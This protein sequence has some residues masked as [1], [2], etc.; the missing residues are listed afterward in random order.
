VARVAC[1]DHVL[2][3]GPHL[4][5]PAIPPMQ[6]DSD[7]GACP[8]AHMLLCDLLRLLPPWWECAESCGRG[9]HARL[10]RAAHAASSR[11]SAMTRTGGVCTAPENQ[12]E[13]PMKKARREPDGGTV[14][15]GGGAARLQTRG[16][17]ALAQPLQGAL[18]ISQRAA[19]TLLCM[20]F[21]TGVFR[22]V[23]R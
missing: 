8:R 1:V 10:S 2:K 5:Q 16:A 9:G 4:Q 19:F 21:D 11:R 23:M 22:A 17:G 6:Q 14:V 18:L 3:C 7:G 13:R 12:Y 20:L 15:D